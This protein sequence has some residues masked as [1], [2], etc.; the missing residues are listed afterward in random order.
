[1]D[2]GDPRCGAQLCGH[3]VAMSLAVMAEDPTARWGWIRENPEIGGPTEG[4]SSWRG[5]EII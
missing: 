2:T 1:V 3:L 4:C 5:A